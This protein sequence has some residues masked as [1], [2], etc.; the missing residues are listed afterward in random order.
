M[1]SHVDG[2]SVLVEF[3]KQMNLQ[4]FVFFLLIVFVIST[5][6]LLFKDSS[7][8]QAQINKMHQ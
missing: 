6:L 8:R 5:A 2:I 4:N 7:T 1:P 3:A